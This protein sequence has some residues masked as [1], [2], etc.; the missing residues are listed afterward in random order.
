MCIFFTPC[1]CPCR[2]PR[3]VQGPG[4]PPVNQFCPPRAP[5]FRLFP[6]RTVLFEYMIEELCEHI[7]RTTYLKAYTGIYL[8][9]IVHTI[10]TGI[11]HNINWTSEL[12]SLVTYIVSAGHTPNSYPQF[13]HSIHRFKS[14]A[15][16][17]RLIHPLVPYAQII[18]LSHTLKSYS[19]TI[20]PSHLLN[21][22]PETI[23]PNHT[24]KSYT[25]TYT[26][27]IRPNHMLQSYAQAIYPSHR[28]KS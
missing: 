3:P 8:H 11:I 18:H 25:Q 14:Y 23:H 15:I 4:Q 2:G 13:I 1:P 12:P 27:T 5:L 9:R 26:Q 6:S 16:F 10:W 28:P 17:I 22:Y 19:Q 24:P 20:R 7:S 21:S